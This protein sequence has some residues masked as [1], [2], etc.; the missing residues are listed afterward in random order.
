MTTKT[1]KIKR[2]T[3]HAPRRR[4]SWITFHA[5]SLPYHGKDYVSFF[6]QFGTQRRVPTKD[7]KDTTTPGGRAIQFYTYKVRVRK[8][9]LHVQG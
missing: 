1:K 9:N 2:T 5:R 6:D 3:T 7:F 8:T 4:D